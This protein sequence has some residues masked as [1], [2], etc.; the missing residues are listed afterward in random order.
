M[1]IWLDVRDD[2]GSAI[3]VP[4]PALEQ[5]FLSRAEAE[6]NDDWGRRWVYLVPVAAE[7]G[8]KDCRSP[9]VAWVTIDDPPLGIELDQACGELLRITG[10]P[11]EWIDELSEQD[12][13]VTCARLPIPSLRAST[14]LPYL[15]LW[16][17]PGFVFPPGRLGLL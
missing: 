12:L 14:P 10:I 5:V 17:T 1:V 13:E 2:K 4:M 11:S 6:P 9:K 15:V 8:E 7:K 16:L 3:E